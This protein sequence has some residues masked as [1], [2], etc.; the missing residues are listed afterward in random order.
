M[1][2][3]SPSDEDPIGGS[4]GDARASDPQLSLGLTAPCL[5]PLVQEALTPSTLDKLPSGGRRECLS[6]GVQT[7]RG[8]CVFHLERLHGRCKKRGDGISIL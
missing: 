3:L 4:R 5:S 2:E 7:V 8:I 1:P 6:R